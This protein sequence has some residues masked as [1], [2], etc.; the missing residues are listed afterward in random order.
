MMRGDIVIV[1]LQGDYGKPRPA[2]VVQSNVI[3]GSH[4]STIVCPITSTILPL[5]FR[6]IIEPDD[7]N[8]LNVASQIMT[9]KVTGIPRAKIGKKIGV[10][11]QK[12]LREVNAALAFLLALPETT[13][14]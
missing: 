2:L 7:R 13:N 8:G 9:D 14:S 4:A 11:D 1:S 3:P 6:V 10:L 12:G 5:D